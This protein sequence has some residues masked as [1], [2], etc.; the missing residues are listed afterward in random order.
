MW[1]LWWC[2]GCVGMLF[3]YSYVWMGV[4]LRSILKTSSRKFVGFCAHEQSY[5]TSIWLTGQQKMLQLIIPSLCRGSVLPY[6]RLSNCCFWIMIK[7]NKLLTQPIDNVEKIRITWNFD[8]WKWVVLSIKWCPTAFIARWK[9]VAL[10][11]AKRDV[12]FK[13]NDQFPSFCDFRCN[14]CN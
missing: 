10:S 3:I 14:G 5:T 12:V 6:A 13:S 9:W 7:F 8:R 1:S 2:K 4:S 11:N